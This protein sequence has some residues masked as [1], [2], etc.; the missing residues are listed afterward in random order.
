M[1]EEAVAFEFSESSS[2]SE[3]SAYEKQKIDSDG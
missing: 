2:Y 1:I 3:S